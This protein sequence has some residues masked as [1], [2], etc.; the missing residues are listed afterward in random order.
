MV[1][2]ATKTT[3]DHN[4]LMAHHLLQVDNEMNFTKNERN[5]KMVTILMNTAV[6]DEDKQFS[7][8]CYRMSKMV[9]GASK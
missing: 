1:G 4:T 9:S 6:T 8:W 3:V 5:M 7:Q 2:S